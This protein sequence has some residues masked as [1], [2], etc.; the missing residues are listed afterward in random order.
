MQRKYS[1]LGG[2]VCAA[3][4]FAAFSTSAASAKSAA[5]HGYSTPAGEVQQQLGSP[6]E[7]RQARATGIDRL[8][9]TGID[10]ALVLAAGLVLMTMGVTIRRLSRARP[11][12]TAGRGHEFPVR[13]L[14]TESGTHK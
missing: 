2:L 13:R 6:G 1:T 12:G 8:P 11:E 7:T 10:I 14:T 9:F 5:Q 3:L 4:L